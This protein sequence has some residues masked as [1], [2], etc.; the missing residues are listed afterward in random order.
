MLRIVVFHVLFWRVGEE[1]G[2]G[3]GG[4]MLWAWLFGA[5]LGLAARVCR[6]VVGVPGESRT[7]L[8]RV[9]S[10]LPD[11]AAARRRASGRGR[12]RR[13]DVAGLGN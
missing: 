11:S 8:R 13:R 6:P 4:G 12:G 3:S 5:L 7:P 9:L 1:G 2:A 10:G